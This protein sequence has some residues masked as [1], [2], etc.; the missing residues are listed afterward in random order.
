[1][2]FSGVRLILAVASPEDDIFAGG[3][4]CF[5]LWGH[6]ERLGVEWKF[7]FV[8]SWVGVFVIV[9]P[10]ILSKEG[11]DTFQR[12]WSGQWDEG[13]GRRGYVGQWK[14]EEGRSIW[15][16]M[17]CFCFFICLTMASFLC[18]VRW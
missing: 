13:S 10:W 2:N 5:I 12:R 4:A 9:L 6:S 18:L 1:M 8:W 14:W 11:Q 17:Y 15:I 16:S 7:L 3:G